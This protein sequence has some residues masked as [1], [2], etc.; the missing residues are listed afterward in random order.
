MPTALLT[1]NPAFTSACGAPRNACTTSVRPPAFL[2][3]R[4]TVR[5]SSLRRSRAVAGSTVG[6]DHAVS[7]ARPLPRRADTIAR[8]ARVRIRRRNPCLRARRRLLGWKVRLPFATAVSPGSYDALAPV[9]TSRL[10]SLRR[11]VGAFGRT[12]KHP[13]PT[14]DLTRVRTAGELATSDPRLP[15]TAT[16][17]S[18]KSLLPE[19]PCGSAQSLLACRS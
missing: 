3:R 16:R 13:M 19:G 11:G 5:K 15:F 7:F 6:R 4:R 10:V 18:L 12:S 14:G 1:T 2:P 8:P 9:L 17:R